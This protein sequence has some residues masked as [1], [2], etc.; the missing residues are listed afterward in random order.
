MAIVTLMEMMAEICQTTFN[1]K[2]TLRSGHHA[3]R[4]GPKLETKTARNI[5]R[6]DLK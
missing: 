2:A 3:R 4:C 5:G 1:K 6:R